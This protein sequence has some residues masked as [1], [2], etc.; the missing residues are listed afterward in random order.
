MGLSNICCNP[1]ESLDL[2]IV[3]MEEDRLDIIVNNEENYK[4]ILKGN[5]SIF[6]IFGWCATLV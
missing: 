6:V 1:L 5:P 2:H 4:Y 3:E